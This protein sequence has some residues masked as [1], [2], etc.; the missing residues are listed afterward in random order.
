M[1]VIPGSLC[2]SNVWQR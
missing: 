2:I 1:L